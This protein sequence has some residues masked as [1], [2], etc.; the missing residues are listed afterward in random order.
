[1][2]TIAKRVVTRFKKAD[3][4]DDLVEE[5]QDLDDLKDDIEDFVYMEESA[6]KLMHKTNEL[7]KKYQEEIVA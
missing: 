6:T 2:S 4:S 3:R 1:M 5:M 7:A